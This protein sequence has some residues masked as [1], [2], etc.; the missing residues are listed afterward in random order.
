MPIN[1]QSEFFI[2]KQ[3]QKPAN[4]ISVGITWVDGRILFKLTSK[5]ANFWYGIC[6][7]SHGVFAA[8]PLDYPRPTMI[9][10]VSVSIVDRYCD[11]A[12]SCLHFKCPHNNFNKDVFINE[13]SDCGAFTLGLPQNLG[14]EPLWFNHGKWAAA[15]NQFII[16]PEGGRLEYDSTKGEVK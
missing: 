5:W 11:R 3:L 6:N 7:F 1:D 13:F 10:T 16:S 9:T 4:I 8:T 12:Y 15:W 14:S 2:N